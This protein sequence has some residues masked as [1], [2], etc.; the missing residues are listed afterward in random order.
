MWNAASTRGRLHS[1]ALVGVIALLVVALSPAAA[2]G[3]NAAKGPKG[4]ET[5]TGLQVVGT[6]SSSV[7][8]SWSAS[9]RA[10]GYAVF[11]NDTEVGRT[12]TTRY[13]IASL[14]CGTGYLLAVEA[15][16]AAGR[17]SERAS[18]PA[19]TSTCS[20]SPPPAGDSS[21]PTAPS[22]LEATSVSSTG[23]S[24]TWA[25]S[26]DNVGVAGYGVYVGGSLVGSTPTTSY[27][28]SG[29]SCATSY[30]IQVDAFDAA[31]NRSS[32]TGIAV[33]TAAC[34]P[35]PTGLWPA[36][37]YPAGS[38]WNPTQGIPA[39]VTVDPSS[40]SLVSAL[41][42]Q[43][44]TPLLTLRRY[45]TA[46]AVVNGG[47]SRYSIPCTKYSC[48]VERWGSIPV[49]AGARPDP[50]GDG[51]LAVLDYAN[52]REWGFWQAVYNATGDTWSTSSGHAL[53]FSERAA[54]ASVAGLDDANFPGVAGIVTPEELASGEIRH[55]LVFATPARGS[56][57][58]R[59][60]ATVN[61][62]SG[63]S[64]IVN[65]MWFQ[66]DP[67]L[68][69]ESLALKRWEKTIAKALQRYGMF[70]RDG[71]SGTTDIIG[72][73]PVNRGSSRWDLVENDDGSQAFSSS[74]SYAYFSSGFPWSKLRVLR[75]PC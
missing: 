14:A 69:V 40:S 16:D 45:A 6:S 2:G 20:S 63:S 52:G 17:R 48:N 56:G 7:S 53:L 18:I 71:S 61:S 22:G 36:N 51:H 21:P 10:A 47:E 39:G 43:L 58:P 44:G 8:L 26:A 38:I 25:P 49:P 35:S 67:S 12:G 19:S 13:T 4:P 72:E 9:K 59:C 70:V 3:D 15:Y 46:V 74:A 65:G 28:L 23:I 29:L 34:S 68:D 54:P 5:P 33:S 57:S 50:G 27:A 32:R 31:K 73:N 42:G 37:P 55:P 75:S 66:L 11:R 62:G 24:V 30:T 60:P 64:G 1:A 41:V